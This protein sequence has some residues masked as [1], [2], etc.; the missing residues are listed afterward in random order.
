MKVFIKT[1]IIALSIISCSFHSLGVDGAISMEI[2]V[3]CHPKVPDICYGEKTAWSPSPAL[4]CPDPPSN[5]TCVP[6]Y[7]GGWGWE[8]IFVK[9]LEEGTED[10]EVIAGA[11]VFTTRVTIEDDETT[12]NVSISGQDC[13][14]C[15][16]EDCDGFAEIKFNCTN[17]EKAVSSLDE[18]VSVDEFFHPYPLTPISTEKDS[19]TGTK[20]TGEGTDVDALEAG[21]SVVVNFG[22]IFLLTAGAAAAALW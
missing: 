21:S 19:E 5:E 18:C 2:G 1:S 17:L 15:S 22:S 10:P 9:G 7:E 14:M 13:S 6:T 3:T 16:A 11:K 8:Y 4:Y 20:D 12:C